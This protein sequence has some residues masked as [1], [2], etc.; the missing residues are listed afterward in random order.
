MCHFYM[1][2]IYEKHLDYDVLAAYAYKNAVTVG[3]TIPNHIGFHWFMYSRNA[4][5]EYQQILR[6]EEEKR[7][8][9]EEE[10]NLEVKMVLDKIRE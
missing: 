2:Q 10:A 1:G 3:V 6:E 7:E 4:V 9:E 5:A 8:K